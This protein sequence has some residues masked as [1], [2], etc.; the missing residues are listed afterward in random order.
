MARME[1]VASWKN[2]ANLFQVYRLWLE[3][4][5]KTQIVVYFIFQNS[6]HIFLFVFYKNFV[7]D[8]GT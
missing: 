2:E 8:K 1:M 4:L 5:A 6:R 3:K 7:Y